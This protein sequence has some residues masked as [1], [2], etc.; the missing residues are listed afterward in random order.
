[1]G[2]ARE[3][4]HCDLGGEKMFEGGGGEKHF[5]V[6]PSKAASTNDQA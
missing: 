3:K 4:S 2:G 1:M 5:D 6:D